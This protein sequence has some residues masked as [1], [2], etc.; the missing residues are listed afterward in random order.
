MHGNVG[1]HRLDSGSSGIED[2]LKSRN[3][4]WDT[5]KTLKDYYQN[6]VQIELNLSKIAKYYLDL[7]ISKV[8]DQKETLEDKEFITQL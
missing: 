2:H 5:C 4:R 7:G 8:K 3:C 1:F 6:L